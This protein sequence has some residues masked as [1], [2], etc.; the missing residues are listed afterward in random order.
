MTIFAIFVCAVLGFICTFIAG[1][2]VPVRGQSSAF[3]V[4]FFMVCGIALMTV[5]IML[6]LGVW[7]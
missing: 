5:A 7:T 1:G 4:V 6:A 3:P 2:A